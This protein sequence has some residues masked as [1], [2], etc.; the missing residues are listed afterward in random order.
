MTIKQ[1]PEVVNGR[2]KASVEKVDASLIDLAPTGNAIVATTEGLKV[3][4]S[5]Y[6][7]SVDLTN[8]IAAAQL[9]GQEVDLSTYSTKAE[10]A[11]VESDLKD[12]YLPDTYVAKTAFETFKTTDLPTAINAQVA[13]D[14]ANKAD[15]TELAAFKNETEINALIDNR[16]ENIYGPGIATNLEDV[17]G[18]VTQLAVVVET[19]K[20]DKVDGKGLSTNDF[21]G[22]YKDQLDNMTTTVDTQIDD[23]FNNVYGPS[24]TANFEG[25]N[26]QLGTKLDTPTPTPPATTTPSLENSLPLYTL[27]NNGEYVLCTPDAWFLINGFYVPGYSA[28]TLGV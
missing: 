10:V 15:R 3:D 20:V 11:Q 7:T 13:A 14:L 24:L 12:Q 18:R 5:S 4:L 16:F 21:T 28:T 9:E 6:A 22:V 27:G 26:T 17:H 23:K 25:I 2:V 8:A 19:T 1:L